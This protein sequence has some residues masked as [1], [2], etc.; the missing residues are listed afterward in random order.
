MNQYNHP[1]NSRSMSRYSFTDEKTDIR[2]SLLKDTQQA[3]RTWKET[4][5]LNHYI[6]V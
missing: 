6:I 1:H 4:H 2:G 5:A 3:D